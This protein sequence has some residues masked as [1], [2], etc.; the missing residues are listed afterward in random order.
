M[1]G[2]TLGFAL[3][4]FRFSSPIISSLMFIR[5]LFSRSPMS[6]RFRA[7][8]ASHRWV[9]STPPATRSSFNGFHCPPIMRRRRASSPARGA[10]PLSHRLPTYTLGGKPVC[11]AQFGLVLRSFCPYFC[12]IWIHFCLVCNLQRAV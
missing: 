8:G 3:N 1:G 12:L 7:R 5:N 6:A 2:K 9:S 11:L 4:L 10:S